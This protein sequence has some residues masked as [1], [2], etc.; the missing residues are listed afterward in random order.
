MVNDL[1]V[2]VRRYPVVTY[3]FGRQNLNA[4]QRVLRPSATRRFK[5]ETFHVRVGGLLG[6]GHGRD[7]GISIARGIL[8]A[9]H[10]S[11]A[12]ATSLLSLVLGICHMLLSLRLE[13]RLAKHRFHQL[14]LPAAGYNDRLGV[15][16]KA[17]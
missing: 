12:H 14:K 15:S 16:I 17:E 13:S 3:R 8:F 11:K 9:L 4:T 5:Y 7:V 6:M 2:I 10:R 1:H